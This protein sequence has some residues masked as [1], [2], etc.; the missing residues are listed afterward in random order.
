VTLNGTAFGVE[1]NS[2]VDRLGIVSNLE[3]NLRT[4][5]GAAII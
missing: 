3:E 1:F 5:P 2:T 4:K